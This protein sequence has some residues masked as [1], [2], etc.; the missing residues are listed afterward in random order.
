M[1]RTGKG[2]GPRSKCVTTSNPW[3]DMDKL[4]ARQRLALYAALSYAQSNLDDLIDSFSDFGGNLSVGGLQDV[5]PFGE[6]E[7]ETLV[8]MFDPQQPA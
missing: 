3:G 1:T 7:I 8:K 2:C 4:N 5:E 6:D